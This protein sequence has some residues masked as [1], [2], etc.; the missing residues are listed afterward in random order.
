MGSKR[1][2][3]LQVSAPARAPQGTSICQR[4]TGC[5]DFETRMF[6]SP[7]RKRRMR[8]DGPIKG[9]VMRLKAFS[10]F[11]ALGRKK[12]GKA[13]RLAPRLFLFLFLPLGRECQREPWVLAGLGN[14]SASSPPCGMLDPSKSVRHSSERTRGSGGQ[15]S[16]RR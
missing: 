4:G 13:G 16:F 10:S 9:A 2:G 15:R 14:C 5:C 1:G 11:G 12:E 6:P 8:R 7:R 3:A